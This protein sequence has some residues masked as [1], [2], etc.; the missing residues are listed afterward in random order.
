MNTKTA[1]DEL[2][3]I[4][5]HKGISVEKIA[6]DIGTSKHNIYNALKRGD[7]KLS[8]YYDILEHPEVKKL[9]QKSL[10]LQGSSEKVFPILVDNNNRE[11]ISIVPIYA[12]A[13]YMRGYEDPEFIRSLP[14]TYDD[15]H[16]DGTYRDFEIKGDSMEN[17]FFER[18]AIRAKYLPETY[19]DKRLHIG[20]LFVILHK[21]DGIVFK[22]L[23]DHN[24]STGNLTLHSFN[25]Y[26]EDYQ[27]N[28]RD[29]QQLWYYTEYRS[30]RLF[31]QVR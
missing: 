26:Y 31:K 2:A 8:L 21:T 24:V 7:L 16:D 1:I 6:T 30:R 11:L 12:Q 17:Y 20:Q 9:Q 5:N 22:Q 14:L 13:G 18:D 15:G 19:W 10:P 23:V 29:V 27:V 4:F 28:L 25:D 3:E